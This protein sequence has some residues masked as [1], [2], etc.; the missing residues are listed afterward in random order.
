[1]MGAVLSRVA[2]LVAVSGC[3]VI[4]MSNAPEA[5]RQAP[6]CES[7]VVVPV[8]DIVA[9]LASV[10]LASTVA[11]AIRTEDGPRLQSA[12]I[13]GVGVGLGATFGVSS[14]VGF[15]RARRCRRAID[16]WAASSR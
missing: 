1:M 6:Q 9:A 2:L 13:L 7:A 11:L 4:M 12:A 3:S 15:G 16:T 5:P 14:A 8:V 10:A